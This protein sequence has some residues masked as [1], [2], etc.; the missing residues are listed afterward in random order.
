MILLLFF[1]SS[2]YLTRHD[3]R[4]ILSA[5]GAPRKP[6]WKIPPWKRK[7]RL[8]LSGELYLQSPKHSKQSGSRRLKL[9]HKLQWH[10]KMSGSPLSKK[11]HRRRGIQGLK[12]QLGQQSG[13]IPQ[14]AVRK[15]GPYQPLQPRPNIPLRRLPPTGLH[16]QRQ[17]WC[18]SAGSRMFR[19]APIP[20]PIRQSVRQYTAEKTPPP[21]PSAAPVAARAMVLNPGTHESDN[22][23]GAEINHHRARSL[24]RTRDPMHTAENPINALIFR[25]VRSLSRVAV[26]TSTK[27]ILTNSD[28]W[29]VTKPRSS[30]RF[31]P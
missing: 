10:K 1:L 6:P 19:H 17:S 24:I 23:K 26:P 27:A 2:S 30:Q 28:G 18:G 31:A 21:V 22:D 11:R 5:P 16:W 3:Y 15:P 8:S 13:P 7:A 9:L 20:F 12:L 29:K 4:Q 25:V 14:R